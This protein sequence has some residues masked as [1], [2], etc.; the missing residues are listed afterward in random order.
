MPVYKA[1]V[2]NKEINVNYE[3]GQKEKLVEAVNSINIKLNALG[4]SQGKI[5]DYKLLSFLAIQLQAELIDLNKEKKI[6]PNLEKKIKK[7]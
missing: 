5:S 1:K 3:D 2:L 7:F 4:S 6:D